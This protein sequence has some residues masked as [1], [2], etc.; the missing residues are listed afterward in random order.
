[1]T[2]VY[3]GAVRAG[4]ARNGFGR[5]IHG[6]GMQNFVGYMK[7]DIVA[8]GLTAVGKGVFFE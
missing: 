2:Q 4:M 1:M 3:E 7:G 8:E 5:V 6:E